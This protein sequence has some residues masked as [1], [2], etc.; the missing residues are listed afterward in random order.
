MI[1]KSFLLCVTIFKIRIS[2][3]TSF[4]QIGIA[5]CI[6]CYQMLILQYC[7]IKC[8]PNI[9]GV[10]FLWLCYFI[11]PQR[12]F[13][14]VILAQSVRTTVSFTSEQKTFGVCTL[15]RTQAHKHELFNLAKSQ[16]I[17]QDFPVFILFQ[18]GFP[19]INYLESNHLDS[20]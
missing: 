7:K 11:S 1:S 6:C 16:R 20:R 19:K 9:Y 5:L 15:Y 2:H 17:V 14:V 13:Q 8:S 12:L 4:K 18:V 3:Y 10:A